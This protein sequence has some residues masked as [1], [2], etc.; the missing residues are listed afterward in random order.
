MRADDRLRQVTPEPTQP[1]DHEA[2]QR[3]GRRARR[4]THGIVGLALAGVVG[5]VAIAAIQ[6]QPPQPVVLTQPTPDEPSPTANGAADGVDDADSADHAAA[7]DC[8]DGGHWRKGDALPDSSGALDDTLPTTCRD[9]AAVEAGTW[10]GMDAGQALDVLRQRLEETPERPEG[11]FALE[12]VL[13][14]ELGA[15][16]VRRIEP[17][18]PDT[19]SP[20]VTVLEPDFDGGETPAYLWTWDQDAARRALDG[21][22]GDG[23]VLRG[24]GVDR[25]GRSV[26]VFAAPGSGQEVHIDPDSGYTAG[27]LVTGSWSDPELNEVAET[28]FDDQAKPE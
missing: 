10:S 6:L 4:M 23:W 17:G 18:T 21:L 16:Q 26:L 20:V 7:P 12:V 8:D 9:E 19:D 22:Q 27:A 14:R 13:D 15:A 25:A 24:P 3:R 28:L 11:L 1:L 5:G 2:L